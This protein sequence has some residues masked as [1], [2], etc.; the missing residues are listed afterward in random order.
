MHNYLDSESIFRK[1]IG[2]KRFDGSSDDLHVCY[3]MNF[4]GDVVQSQAPHLIDLE[5]QNINTLN[6]RGVIGTPATSIRRPSDR[7]HWSAPDHVF[8]EATAVIMSAAHS[9]HDYNYNTYF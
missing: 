2:H 3:R 9:D 7:S 4:A 5:I 6:E 1:V 8:G